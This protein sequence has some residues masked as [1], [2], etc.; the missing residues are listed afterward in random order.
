MKSAIQPR[1][2][3]LNLAVLAELGRGA[4]VPSTASAADKCAACGSSWW[5]FICWCSTLCVVAAFGQPQN[6]SNV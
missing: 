2:R 6:G 4:L 3:L 1:M 5:D